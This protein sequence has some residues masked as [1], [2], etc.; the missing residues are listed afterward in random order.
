MKTNIKRYSNIIIYSLLLLCFS[1]SG[2][3]QNY[4]NKV[5]H[6]NDND[7]K[8][9]NINTKLG[10]EFQ[11]FKRSTAIFIPH[12][13]MSILSTRDKTPC[14]AVLINPSTQDNQRTYM[15]TTASCLEKVDAK[16]RSKGNAF[17]SFDYEMIIGPFDKNLDSYL[18]DQND[19]NYNEEK[20]VL[21]N[22]KSAITTMYPVSYEVLVMQPGSKNVLL[23]ITDYD[24]NVFHNTYAVGW[25]NELFNQSA[26][27]KKGRNNNIFDINNR[28]TGFNPFYSI[29]FPS[30]DHKKIYFNPDL[31]NFPL[32]ALSPIN[33]KLRD[34][35]IER[36][37]SN[38]I[39]DEK[40]KLGE[41]A[42]VNKEYKRKNDGAFG[43]GAN[44]SYPF[45]Y[46]KWNN[47]QGS[48]DTYASFGTIARVDGAPVG[49]NHH[50]GALGSGFFH[51]DRLK[52]I[53]QS[54]ES[55]AHISNSFYA[56]LK[57]G[58]SIK[59][60]L[61]PNYLQRYLDRDRTF[62]N[63]V[64]STNFNFK[65]EYRRLG[66]NFSINLELDANSSYETPSTT[67]DSQ[68]TLSDDVIFIPGD[69]LFMNL[70]FTTSKKIDFNNATW[71]YL[72]GINL[73]ASRHP[74]FQNLNL[75]LNIYVLLKNN[76]NKYEK[77]LYRKY[78]ID[79]NLSRQIEDGNE[80]QK[81]NRLN[82]F[83]GR[84]QTYGI[85]PRG[86][87]IERI[88]NSSDN[89]GDIEMISLKGGSDF[90]V[91]DQLLESNIPVVIELKNI[92]SVKTYVNAI[93]Y[94]GDVPKNAL[95]FYSNFYS[96]LSTMADNKINNTFDGNYKY[97][98]ARLNSSQAHIQSIMLN[99]KAT[100]RDGGTYEKEV[101]TKDN[102]GYVNLDN[103][104]NGIGPIYVPRPLANDGISDSQGDLK[105]TIELGDLTLASTPFMFAAWIDFFNNESLDG[106][107]RSNNEFVFG[108]DGTNLNRFPHRA[109]Q[110]IEPTQAVLSIDQNKVSK[111]FIIPDYVTL[112]M[113]PGSERLAR[114]RLVVMQTN[115]PDDLQPDVYDETKFGEVE[116]Y[117]VILRAPTQNEERAVKRQGLLQYISSSGA[118]KLDQARQNVQRII[119]DAH[120]N[121]KRT[122]SASRVFTEE[123]I[124][125]MQALGGQASNTASNI[126]TNIQEATSLLRS[127]DGNRFLGNILGLIE[128]TTNP[129]IVQVGESAIIFDGNELVTIGDTEESDPEGDLMYMA[130]N[131]HTTMFNIIPDIDCHWYDNEEVCSVSSNNLGA[132]EFE[133]L[134]EEGDSTNGLSVRF[135]DTN[136]QFGVKI[137]GSPL[138][139]IDYALPN[140]MESGVYKVIL[141]SF[142][143]GIMKLYVDGQK[144]GENTYFADNNIT[145][146]PDHFDQAGLGGFIANEDILDSGSIWDNDTTTTNTYFHGIIDYFGY[147][148]GILDDATIEDLADDVINPLSPTT[149]CDS[150]AP[151][152]YA[153]FA[154][155]V[156]SYCGPGNYKEQKE[157]LTNFYKETEKGS[158][159]FEVGVAYDIPY[160]TAWGSHYSF[161]GRKRS[162][163]NWPL[164][165][166]SGVTA[167]ISNLREMLL[168]RAEES[169]ALTNP[170]KFKHAPL[171][172]DVF[173]PKVKDG[174]SETQL[175]NGI[176]VIIWAFGG[177][178]VKNDNSKIDLEICRWLASKG[179]IVA[180]IDYRLGMNL[181]DGE[182]AKRAPMRA[183]QDIRAAVQYWKYVD[184]DNSTP[185]G[186]Y[187]N[188]G[189]IWKVNPDKVYGL[190]W[191]AGGITVLNN[192][193]LD[194][195]TFDSEQQPNS[196]GS[197]GYLAA[198]AEDYAFSAN[199]YFW[200]EVIIPS[201]IA[202]YDP[203]A[204]GSDI[205]PT[206][207]PNGLAKHLIDVSGIDDVSKTALKSL[208]DVTAI[209]NLYNSLTSTT[210]FN[211]YALDNYPTVPCIDVNICDG[212]SP[213][214]DVNTI[215]SFRDQ[216]N[217][218]Y[219][220]TS[221]FDKGIAMAGAI[222]KIEWMN[223]EQNK[224]IASIHH[225]EDAIINVD[226][227]IPFDELYNLSS[228]KN[229][230]NTYLER[231][232]NKPLSTVHGGLGMSL[233]AESNNL[234]NYH[235]L[236]LNDDL[237]AGNTMKHN[238]WESFGEMSSEEIEPKIMYYVDAFLM[239][240]NY[241]NVSNKSMPSKPITDANLNIN[242]SP[243]DFSIF[244]N[245]AVNEINILVEVR[246]EGALQVDIYDMT[247]RRVYDM[248]ESSISTGHQYINIQN[249][250]LSSGNYILRIKAGD[251]Q[252]SEQIIIK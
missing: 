20:Q 189:H 100:H 176:P 138:Q 9:I 143:H 43:F 118:A 35:R 232:I 205:P 201:A 213:S 243:A 233:Y 246:Q 25:N 225:V 112:N 117:L 28:Y 151:K 70:P 5:G 33:R 16:F 150:S 211:T 124:H 58:K 74:D 77:Y 212:T 152:D 131:Q 168:P 80:V 173:Y 19:P 126:A 247:G 119:N 106:V 158:L 59:S 101:F 17:L 110:I 190:G 83:Y 240:E 193:Y 42:Y 104:S 98:K 196:D 128:F 159:T 76:L 214:Q 134:Y 78:S 130:Y 46:Y 34:T 26:L 88:K 206:F 122:G 67:D 251:V 97:P 53:Q 154:E 230:Y 132:N 95:Q 141:I 179:Y 63:D 199:D 94:P 224:P 73:D 31:T 172:M 162:L 178:F 89:I 123:V 96:E 170:D 145:E 202:M 140:G 216:I 163:E 204:E 144:V 203:S 146:L 185:N 14:T 177:G 75:E 215:K 84:E 248:S 156:L 238:V 22:V 207:T 99:Q 191:S 10:Y 182:L 160:A 127:G 174:I 220:N 153:M 194:D 52:A 218:D 115:N 113:A 55:F 90:E 209:T 252:R 36:L 85:K 102:G 6:A 227:G 47:L 91:T 51:H 2:F 27:D 249:L 18:P 208:I 32:V 250:N 82:N 111:K 49:A 92:G 157:A 24:E 40:L 245:P 81:I 61:E 29:S 166:G 30:G 187:S 171:Y 161:L 87:V 231:A 235:F 66:Q 180:A 116:D 12:K 125:E 200:P 45:R 198:V 79:S 197:D 242:M 1:W 223:N 41:F 38:Q 120:E 114:M 148:L 149:A 139:K 13:D 137:E 186:I 48:H 167:E 65:K 210:D 222:P 8:T 71:S 226:E 169:K 107:N 221:Q 121:V 103:F 109:E 236:E 69:V 184:T 165:P 142:D 108:E 133:V 188:D 234:D 164:V 50:S 105:L 4:D 11:N 57:Q 21:D 93:A 68:T 219:P 62:L 37:I 3:G 183:W 72:K 244:P 217:A 7:L 239:Q 229:F 147:D 175:N 136:L 228:L 241:Q 39:T 86:K 15:M 237:Q 64:P 54:E 60:S 44:N 23:E 155:D 56:V 135:N 195:N 129:N 192:L 181:S